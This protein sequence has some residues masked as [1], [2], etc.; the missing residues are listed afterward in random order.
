MSQACGSVSAASFDRMPPI[1]LKLRLLAH[2][3]KLLD[4]MR[5]PMKSAVVIAALGVLATVGLGQGITDPVEQYRKD[6]ETNPRSSLAHFRIAEI[7]SARA[8]YQAAANEFRS[9]L[10]G[11][12]QPRWTE[13]WA[14]I[15]M[16]RIFDITNQHDR[17]VKEYQ[18]AWGTGDNTHGALTEANEYLQSVGAG[19]TRTAPISLVR[20]A[21]P[22]L[23][24][25]TDPEYSD[26]ARV[27]EIEGTVVVAGVAGEAGRARDL[28][29]TQHLGLG[30]DEKA[31]ETVQQWR[32]KPDTESVRV[33]VDFSLP[34]KQSLWHLIGVDFHPPEGATRPIVLSAYYPTG[35]GVF[36][37]AA[38]EEGRLLGA[39][40]RQ[41]FIALS[42]DVDENGVPIQIQ[43][44]T[45]SDSVWNDQATA[46]LRQWRFTPG[47]KDGKPVSVPCTFD[48]VWGPR[49]LG[50]KEV[51]QLLTA[52]HPPPGPSD[53]INPP[54]VI[55][56]P[57]PPYSEQARNAGLEGTVTVV[58][59]VGEDGTPRD[60]RIA[61]GLE[62]TIDESVTAAIGKWRFSPMLLNGQVASPGFVVE[63]RFQLPNS[64]IARVL[65]PPIRA[66]ASSIRLAPQQ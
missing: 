24:S 33:T 8:N 47:M 27:A 2:R 55:Y 13:V 22:E 60:I 10:S 9:A 20:S 38:I 5:R 15:N 58:L 6:L 65:S 30:L 12:L 48:F 14:H 52:L 17:A 29:V 21:P 32:F 45:S 37:G 36:S 62:P 49:N 28:R 19:A 26:E 23:L 16:G 53:D 40:G 34:S 42:F 35:A 39:I 18:I 41:A 50:S 57:V 56:S 31:I 59:R 66:R 51:A 25:R 64:V 3:S 61:Q 44:E 43:V 11:D 1:N 54:A 46:V 7:L 63:V 4:V